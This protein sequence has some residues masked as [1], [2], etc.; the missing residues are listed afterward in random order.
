[1]AS[2][3]TYLEISPKQE[4]LLDYWYSHIGPCGCAPRAA[5]N[6]GRVR[7]LLSNI[8]IVEL[9]QSGHST[10]RLAG[11][12][13]RDIVGMEARGRSV[14]S[15]QGGELEPWCDAILSVLDTRAPI[16]GKIERED[17]SIHMWLRLPL[18]DR[19][20]QLTQVMC[21]DELYNRN[22]R[23]PL[24]HRRIDDLIPHQSA[25]YAA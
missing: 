20:G 5:I 13:L 2:E 18:L 23:R 21:H 8:S 9:S 25:R 11:S 3:Q 19:D 7:E 12:K 1:M 10:F 15:I 22:D 14:S 17:G 4:K 24:K 16:A 6:P